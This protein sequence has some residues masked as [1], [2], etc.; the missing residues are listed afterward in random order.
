MSFSKKRIEVTVQLG[1]GKF[2]EDGYDTVTLNDHRAIVNISTPGGASMGMLQMR[3]YGLSEDLMNR[4]TTIGPINSQIRNNTVL[5]SA[6]DGDSMAQVYAGTLSDV[7]ADYRR[8]PEVSLEM[9]AQSGLIEAVRPI[10]PRSYQGSADAAL[11]MAD[12]A[13]AMNVAF[14]NNGVSVQ[15]ANP[16]FSGTAWQQVLT[17]AQ[18]ANINFA[19]HNG[20]L[21]IWPRTG[22]RAGGI[23]MLTPETGLVGYPTFSSHGIILTS[24]FNPNIFIGGFVDVKSSLLGASGRWQIFSVTHEISSEVP[25]GPWFTHL[26]GSPATATGQVNTVSS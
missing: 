24:T 16:Y 11:I 17:C 6:G 1:R 15:L 3:A 26:Q 14:E 21:A 25:G 22:G 8:A 13:K 18:A 20:I 23:P 4:L 10:S 12:L 9:M 2:G 19:L 7:W 5:I